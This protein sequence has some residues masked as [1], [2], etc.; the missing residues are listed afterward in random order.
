MELSIKLAGWVL[1]KIPS[2]NVVEL[3]HILYFKM[4]TGKLIYHLTVEHLRYCGDQAKDVPPSLDQSHSQ[5]HIYYLTCPQ[6][7]LGLGT[8][9]FKAKDKLV[10]KSTSYWRIT[11]TPI[12]GA[13]IDYCIN[14][15]GEQIFRPH[16][17][18][19]QL[20]FTSGVSYL[21]A[22]IK[23]GE[24]QRW[25]LEK[26]LTCFDVSLDGEVAFP[27]MERDIKICE[28]YANGDRGDYLEYSRN[29]YKNTQ[30]HMKQL[31]RLS[32]RFAEYK[33]NRQGHVRASGHF[34]A[35]IN[36]CLD[37]L[38]S[39]GLWFILGPHCITPCCIADD[40]YVLTAS[41]SALQAALNIVSH[42]GQRYHLKFLDHVFP[43]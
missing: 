27:S 33:G 22:A 6:I 40:T 15:V 26:K 1:L 20:G 21:L 5:W 17:S 12:L 32:R 13:I 4:K 7:K 43:I 8:A 28:L 42:Y 3:N 39:C 30:C 38:Y 34:K 23:R 18:K 36:P 9:V 35:F 41:A 10:T 25:A 29:S 31:G 24:C 2:M 16:Q 19:D 14:P 37:T 11:V